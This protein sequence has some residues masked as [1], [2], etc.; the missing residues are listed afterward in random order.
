MM[1]DG[2]MAQRKLLLGNQATMLRRI[3]RGLY[4]H[5]LPDLPSNSDFLDLNAK[6]AQL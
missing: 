5:G 1:F 2:A 3:A 4:L 6:E